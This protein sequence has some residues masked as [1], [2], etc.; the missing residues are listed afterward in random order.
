MKAYFGD[1]QIK[2]KPYFQHSLEKN[3]AIPFAGLNR[4]LGLREVK[5]PRISKQSAYEG[6]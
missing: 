3:K 6:G 1:T 5:V 4:S 2:S